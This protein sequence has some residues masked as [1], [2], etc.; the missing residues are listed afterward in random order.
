MR[1]T[2]LPEGNPG[3][4]FFLSVV[5]EE[6]AGSRPEAKK[7]RRRPKGSGSVYKLSGERARPYVALTAKGMF[8]ERLKRQAKQ[9]KRWTLTTPRT[10]PLRF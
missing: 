5:R 8:W 6:T 3:W 10:P 2:M 4:C 9:Y 1:E 7:K